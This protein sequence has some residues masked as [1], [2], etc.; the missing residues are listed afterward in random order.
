MRYGE[1]TPAAETTDEDG[2]IDTERI[3]GL[4]RTVFVVADPVFQLRTPQALNAIWARRGLDLVTIPAHITVAGLGAFVDGMRAAENAAG[5]VMTVPHKQSAG[6]YCDELGPNAKL[7]GSINA[8][9]REN[10]RLIGETFDGAGFVAGLRARDFDLAGAH[11][12]LLGAGGAASSIAVAL[13]RAGIRSLD[14]ENRTPARAEALARRVADGLGFSDVRVG[15]ERARQVQLVVNA[16]SN[17]MTPGAVSDFGLDPFPAGALAADV[18]VS[19]EPTPFLAAARVQ[20]LQLHEGRHMLHGQ[21][22]AIA[23]FLST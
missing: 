20:G 15:R 2:V 5:A 9:R 12:Q 10:G 7:T 11:V 6:A 18:I 1:S 21:M 23:D 4:T 13:V 22:E 16:T 17:G 19:D 14:I 8:I 3:S